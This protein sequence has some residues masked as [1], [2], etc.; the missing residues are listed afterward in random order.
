MN[1]KAEFVAP[2]YVANM[3]RVDS[4]AD[5]DEILR[6]E[7][8]M[9][10]SHRESGV[11]FDGSLLLIEGEEHMRRRQLISSLVSRSA[12]QYY[13]TGALAPVIEQ[14]MKELREKGRDKDGVVRVDLIPLIR[15]M[16]YRINALVTGV[17]S[18]DTPE[19]TERFRDLV[20]KLGVAVTVEWSTRDHDEVIREGLEIRRQLI[21][22]FLLP[23]L[24]RRRALVR[25]FRDGKAAKETLPTD[26]LTMLTLHGDDRRP[27]DEG[28]VWRECALFLVAS[29]QTTTHTL[30]HV[31]VHLTEWCRTHP[32]DAARCTDP[33]FLRIAAMES[34]RLHQPAPTLLRIALKD[35]TLSSGRRIARDERVALFFVPA[36]RE[37]AVF[38]PDAAEFNLNR[39][40]PPRLSPWGLTFGGGVHMCIGRPLVTGMF[41]RPDD[42]SG[43]E[44]TMIRILRTLYEAGAEMDP[45]RPP[46]RVAASYHDAYESFPLILRKL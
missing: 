42:K 31:I 45:E 2:P 8:F 40:A 9:Q 12:M 21:E 36:N 22:E 13:E 14:V 1:A 10:G 3:Q 37:T 46:R 24:E 27:G 6:S 23:S 7:D 43:T 29:T 41:N 16:L 35:V 18:V 26:L 28:Y 33:T 32:A 39:V 25:E 15:S 34:L 38:G 4:Y 44:G 5:I 30:P 19:K 17:D 20:D 11:F